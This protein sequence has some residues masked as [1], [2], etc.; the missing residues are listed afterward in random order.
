MNK[1]LIVIM[2]II[3]ILAG[4]AFIYKESKTTQLQSVQQNTSQSIQQIPTITPSSVDAS[5]SPQ[6]QQAQQNLN[7]L[8]NGD[9]N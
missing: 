8:D 9:N 1:T 4:G 5:S 7:S 2:I 3:V 6:E